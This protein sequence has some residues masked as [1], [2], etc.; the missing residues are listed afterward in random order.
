MKEVR[1]DGKLGWLVGI[2]A[3]LLLASCP[4]HAETGGG[5]A[6][7]DGNQRTQGGAMPRIGQKA[8]PYAGPLRTQGP[9]ETGATRPRSEV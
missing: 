7:P 8:P 5:G 6:Q 2:L 9:G 4:R 3:V 1:M